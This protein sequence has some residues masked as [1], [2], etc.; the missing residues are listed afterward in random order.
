MLGDEVLAAV[1][2]VNHDARDEASLT[3]M[4]R[5]GADVPVWLN[6]EWARG[7][8]AHHDGLRRAALLRRLLRRPEA[9]RARARGPRDDADAAR[10]RA[11][12]PP[13]RALGR[14]RTAIPCTTTCAR[15][16]RRRART[17]RST[18]CSTASSAS[19]R[20]SAASCSRC[21][22]RRAPSCGRPRCA[23]CRARSTSCSRRTPAS[24]STRTSTR[25]SRACRRRRRSCA[26][27]A[28]S[29]ARPSA[30][31]ASPSHGSYREELTAAASPAALL[32]AIAARTDDGARPVADPDPGGHPGALARDRAHLVPVRRRARRRRTSSRRA[33][34]EATVR[35][36]LDDAGPGRA[37]VRAALR[38][39]DR[40][41]RRRSPAHL[42]R[43]AARAPRAGRRRAR[44]LLAAAGCLAACGCVS[45]AARAA[46]G[47][48]A[49]GGRARLEPRG[50][51]FQRG[52][53]EKGGSAT[54]PS[55]I[56]RGR[57]GSK[58]HLLADASRHPALLGADRRQ[59]PR[60]HPTRSRCSSA[61]RPSSRRTVRSRR[62]PTCSSPTAATTTRDS[63]AAHASAAL[64]CRIASLQTGYGEP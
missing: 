32:E 59:P 14:H 18:S 64:S 22:R 39:A 36:L 25:R 3:W 38:A 54:G 63:A 30:A 47:G 1:R 49:S 56:D 24:R 2:V 5:F 12:R 57:P 37:R 9:R 7:R 40:S 41:L 26:R 46:A 6:S 8:R 34:V 31:T 50:R 55:P 61:S 53:G 17:S 43:L 4:G 16:P 23:R 21:T 35:Q 20:R 29:C 33:D 19:R 28:R 52:A 10:R 60:H 62:R 58:Y 27:A 13:G 11:H 44:D 45:E 42:G 48:A 15:S 51:G